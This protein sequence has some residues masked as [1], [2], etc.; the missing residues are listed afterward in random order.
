MV[1]LHVTTREDIGLAEALEG[2]GR[3][4]VGYCI[5]PA[6][7]Q[8]AQWQSSGLF[9]GPGQ[10]LNGDQLA[11]QIYEARFFGADGE[12]RWQRGTSR[13]QKGS[14][15]AWVGEAELTAVG[16]HQ[17][18]PLH[19]L[20]PLADG[21]RLLTGT[22]GERLDTGWWRMHAPRHG[23]VTVPIGE[24]QPGWRPAYLVREYLGNAAGAAGEDGNRIVVEERMVGIIALPVNGSK[25]EVKRHD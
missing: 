21:H 18:D 14:R 23:E 17:A 8:F 2:I 7:F 5:S 11:H 16:W 15:A 1:A 10:P 25:G 20:T 12:L 13:D 4:L 6:A 19:D 9:C 3:P 22:L 24:A